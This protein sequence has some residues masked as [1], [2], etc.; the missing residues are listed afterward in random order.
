MIPP[1]NPVKLERDA[2]TFAHA[3]RL[4][5]GLDALAGADRIE[6][7]AVTHVDSAGLALLLAVA[8]RKG[9]RLTVADAPA[10]LRSLVAF[11]GV[12]G[13]LDVETRQRG[14]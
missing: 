10:Q 12:D 4:F 11:F 7:S 1:R 6:L 8:R 3:E 2:L 14:A 9:G 13:I 5:A